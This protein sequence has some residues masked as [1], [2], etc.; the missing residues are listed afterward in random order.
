M[1]ITS[2]QYLIDPAQQYFQYYNTWQNPQRASTFDFNI[3][4]TPYNGLIAREN[5]TAMGNIN[6]L[7]QERNSM[8]LG[9]LF[10]T[11]SWQNGQIANSNRIAHELSTMNDAGRQFM[12]TTDKGVAALKAAGYDPK[13]GQP[14]TQQSKSADGATPQAQSTGSQ[15]A[16]WAQTG[17]AAAQAIG[18][19]AQ[20]YTNW[21]TYK[22]NKKT[23]ELQRKNLQQQMALQMEQWNRYKAQ[24]AALNSSWSGGGVVKGSEGSMTVGH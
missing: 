17:L 7:M 16:G 1:A 24:A 15:A 13:T 4:N 10:N 23:N 5:G 12:A 3:N 8:S 18:S 2:N 9:R 22:D 14:M 21:M 20:A 19:L 6:T 11:E